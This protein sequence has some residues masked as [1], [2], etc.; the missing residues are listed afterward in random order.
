MITNS[1]LTLLKRVLMLISLCILTA[2]SSCRTVE[3]SI[4]QT[5]VKVLLAGSLDGVDLVPL[6]PGKEVTAGPSGQYTIKTP[7]MDGGYSEFA[8]IIRYNRHDPL[9]YEIVALRKNKKTIRELSLADIYALPRSGEM[10]T[11]SIDP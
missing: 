8:F 3:V 1:R 5:T 2:L 7:S 10:F 11:L 6:G 9:T 4:P